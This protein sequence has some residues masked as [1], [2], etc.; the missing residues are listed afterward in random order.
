M[1][2]KRRDTEEVKQE[3]ANQKRRERHALVKEGRP[4]K[5]YLYLYY[6]LIVYTAAA[7]LPTPPPAITA[8]AKFQDFD[9][10][11]TIPDT[12]PGVD[13][14]HSEAVYG[15]IVH[16]EPQT[17]GFWYKVQASEDG[18]KITQIYNDGVF[19][20]RSVICRWP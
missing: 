12:T 18:R 20:W 13:F 4:S 8:A 11:R 19:R 6:L 17:D 14:S 15:R 2:R 3:A 9:Q 16:V 7:A 5:H 10:V 1:R